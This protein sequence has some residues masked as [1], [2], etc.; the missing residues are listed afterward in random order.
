MFKPRRYKIW[1]RWDLHQNNQPSSFKLLY[2]S[3]KGQGC[4]FTKDW[5]SS[6]QVVST[7]LGT[8]GGFGKKNSETKRIFN[9]L[10]QDIQS[11]IKIAMDKE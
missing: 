8:P 2:D 6:G 5:E 9:L 1:Y 4:N 10:P 7:G 11:K 3:L